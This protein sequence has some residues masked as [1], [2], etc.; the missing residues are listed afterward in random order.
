M[1]TFY[2]NNF[3]YLTKIHVFKN[4]GGIWYADFEFKSVVFL[5]CKMRDTELIEMK[6]TAGKNIAD[7]I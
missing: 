5:I 4:F 1:V 7:I 6:L 2:G 3:V